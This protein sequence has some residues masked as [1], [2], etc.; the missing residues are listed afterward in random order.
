MNARLEHREVLL[1]NPQTGE[2]EWVKRSDLVPS[3]KTNG[4][5]KWPIHS[6]AMAVLPSQI[7]EAQAY[8]ASKGVHA[9]YD[10]QGRCIWNDPGHR[11]QVCEAFDYYDRN[12]GY[13]DPQRK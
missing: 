10:E 2:L 7:P 9:N 3:K 12:G 1:R 13:S 5:A 8:L 4:I 6:E 11:K